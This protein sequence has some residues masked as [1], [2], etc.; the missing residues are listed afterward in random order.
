MASQTLV[1]RA[2]ATVALGTGHVMRCLALAQAWQDQGGG[3]V[4]VLAEPNPAVAERLRAEGIE[5]VTL[6]ASPGSAE[7]AA[8]LIELAREKQASW[9]VVDGYHFCA[10]YQRALKDAGLKQL[11][12]DDS[13]HAETYCADLVLD[14]NA[15]ARESFYRHREPNTRLLLGTRYA[16]LRREFA[17][18]RDWKREIAPVGRKVL[19]TMGG[20]DPENVTSL[21]IHALRRVKV[22]E[23]EA[24][25]VVGG[26][27]TNLEAIEQAVLRSA[28]PIKLQ[29]R[30]TKMAELMAWA[31][32]AVC[33][34]GT[35][36]WEMCLL[37]LPAILIDLAANQRPVAAE[38]DRRG[39]AIHL[40]PS[41]ELSIA[42]VAGKLEWILTSEEPRAA[43]SE[44]GRELVDGRGA[45]RVVA[46]IR[47]GTLHLRR[48]ESSDCRLI[49]EWANDPEVR[50][51]SFTQARIA[52]NQHTDWFARKLGE[53]ACVM[54]IA[55]DENGKPLGQVR[56]DETSKGEAQIH[57][58]IAKERRGSGQ[59]S[60]LIDLAAQSLFAESRLERLHA[61]IKPD[62]HA[63]TRAFEMAEFVRVGNGEVKGCPAV[64]YVRCKQP[65][66]GARL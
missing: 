64:H 50:A 40:G 36:C 48:A 46:A 55:T 60:N 28:L 1:V 4:F 2:D 10:E 13:G 8:Q 19:V 34:A 9:V 58:S 30:V 23:V 17:P 3:C 24:V 5:V 63:S 16:L 41:R 22:P 47:G 25:V 14:Q 54:L 42:E 18:W 27:N 45:A 65:H 15:H 56:C 39:A 7:D 44:R 53:P 32:V 57:V 49:W 35:T 62:N 31:D 66:P 61:W 43:I 37:G 52:W 59:A 20:S 12:V 51:A 33:G 38:L 26:S 11:F 6:P 29:K 21:A